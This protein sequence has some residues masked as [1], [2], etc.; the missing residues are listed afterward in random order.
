MT[1]TDTQEQ[2]QHR[3]QPWLMACF[4]AMIAGDREER[5]HR[6]IEEALEL[7]QSLGCTAHEAH[8]LVDYVY[9][10]DIGEPA[11]EV[12]GVMVTLAALCLANG[13]DMHANGET[14]LSRI[15]TKVEAIRAKQAAKPKH[16]P[17]PMSTPPTPA[18][19]EREAV[20]QWC[21]GCHEVRSV[22]CYRAGCP[23]SDTERRAAEILA[24]EAN[25][26]ARIAILLE[27][28]VD[29]SKAAMIAKAMCDD[30]DR[31]PWQMIADRARKAIDAHLG[32]NEHGSGK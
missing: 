25:E 18:T 22:D 24:A 23:K 9:G 8:Q 29:I 19:E 32:R 30:A 12:G 15:W 6:F 20:A 10:R 26:R 21:S 5:N 17:L 3:V 2:F 31:E 7:V 1:S 4:G 14:E 11:Q 13:L 16:S 27:A 28:L